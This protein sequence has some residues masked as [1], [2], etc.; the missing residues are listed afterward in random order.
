MLIAVISMLLL[1]GGAVFVWHRWSLTQ[2]LT[3]Q[4]AEALFKKGIRVFET[5]LPERIGHFAGE[6]DLWLKKR[7]LEGMTHVPCMLVASPDKVANSHLLTYWEDVF[8]CTISEALWKRVSK[9]FPAFK[10]LHFK[11]YDVMHA[12]DATAGLY[13]IYARWGERPP[14]LQLREEDKTHGREMLR[15]WGMAEGDWFVC[16]HNRERGYSPTDDHY[17]E[18]RNSPLETIIP[19]IRAIVAAGGWV[20][21]MGDPS[22]TRLPEMERVIDYAHSPHRSARLDIILCATAKFFLGNTSGLFG[23][24]TIFGVP[25]ASANFAPI[26]ALQFTCRD[27][28]MPKLLYSERE[29]RLL[30]FPEAFASPAANFRFT[31]QYQEQQLR[32]LDNTAEDIVGLVR[33]MLDRVLGGCD[34]SAED[35]ALQSAFRALFQPGH[36]AYGSA[37]RTSREFLR[38]HLALFT[39]P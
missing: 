1:L 25:V 29:N 26:S 8:A 16:V 35:E 11:C 4:I 36:Y 6:P 15:Q 22:M 30:T 39:A 34:Y 37:A 13:D 33:E 19:A 2:A 10:K 20:V 27:L 31:E 23:V 9:T 3:A 14:V 24:S 32:I 28:S 12:I 38:K 7:A 17:H 5:T 18:Y 21:R